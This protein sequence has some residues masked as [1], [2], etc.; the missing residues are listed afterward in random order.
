MTD[1]EQPRP[2][3]AR[4][5]LLW[6]VLR[7]VALGAFVCCV[8]VIV[9]LVRGAVSG[10]TGSPSDPHGFAAIFETLLALALTPLAVALWA[11][12]RSLRWTRDR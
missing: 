6:R 7:R 10:F 1:G 8:A 3:T 11:L 2:A 4:A 9:L 5:G 12:C